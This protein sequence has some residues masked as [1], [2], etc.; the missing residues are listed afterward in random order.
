MGAFALKF[1]F[2]SFKLSSTWIRMIVSLS[3]VEDNF[4]DYS[5]INFRF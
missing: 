2:S 4:L 5:T 1:D 3:G